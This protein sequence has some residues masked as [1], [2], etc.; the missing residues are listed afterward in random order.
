MRLVAYPMTHEKV[1]L[2]MDCGH[3]NR[4]RNRYRFRNRLLHTSKTDCDCDCDCDSDP[5]VFRLLLLFS[6]QGI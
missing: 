6:K 1:L 4:G 2:F 5:D 3:R